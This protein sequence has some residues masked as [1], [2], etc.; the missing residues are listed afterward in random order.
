MAGRASGAIGADISWPFVRVTPGAT[1]TLE[2]LAQISLNGESDIDDRVPNE[3]S[4]VFELD[5]TNLFRF[6]RFPGFDRFEDGLIATVGGRATAR[7][8]GGQAGSAA[9]PPTGLCGPRR[10]RFP[11]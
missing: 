3:D 9:R 4:L 5:E 11:G 8:A 6:N 1:Y 2:P 7:L 10:R